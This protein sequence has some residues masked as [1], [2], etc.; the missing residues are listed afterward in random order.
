MSEGRIHKEIVDER[1][2]GYV[3]KPQ[4]ER[5]RAAFESLV[6]DGMETAK[7]LGREVSEDQVRREI[8]QIIEPVEQKRDAGAYKNTG[9]RPAKPSDEVYVEEKGNLTEV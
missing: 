8:R 6:K 2:N 7:K 1:L 3:S 4:G 5:D 9:E